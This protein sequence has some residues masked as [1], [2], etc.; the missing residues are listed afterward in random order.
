MINI[1]ADNSIY[2]STLGLI[3]WKIW[4]EKQIPSDPR[5][6]FLLY[7]NAGMGYPWAV[8]NYQ[9]FTDNWNQLKLWSNQAASRAT[10]KTCV[11]GAGLSCLL[12]HL[13][14]FLRLSIMAEPVGGSAPRF[15]SE[16]K[17]STL[18][19]E[20]SG[21]ATLVCPAQASPHPTFR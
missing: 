12:S 7:L 18:E 9:L 17:V 20:V 15:P 8:S 21:P 4:K 14:A 11:R 3:Y 1:N 10:R 5:T 2:S 13:A 19:R 6:L 16:D